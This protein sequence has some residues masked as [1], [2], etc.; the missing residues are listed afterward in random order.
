MHKYLSHSWIKNTNPA[1]PIWNKLPNGYYWLLIPKCGVTSVTT[2][3]R[4]EAKKK[5]GKHD[6][7]KS[8]KTHQ[9]KDKDTTVAIIRHPLER[10]VS[11]YEHQIR[12]K[13]I[14]FEEFLQALSETPDPLNHHATQQ[15]WFVNL[16]KE[17]GRKVDIL[18]PLDKMSEWFYKREM[19]IYNMNRTEHV[20]WENYYVGN[21]LDMAIERFKDDLELY[22]RAVYECT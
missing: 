8:F 21:L 5:G 17:D 20:S 19:Y 18:I 1:H 4:D 12:S 14:L 7:Y 15:S 11:C 10:V 9:I 3:I 6:I 22:R 2:F 13:G 16:A